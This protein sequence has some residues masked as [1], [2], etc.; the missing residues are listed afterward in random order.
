MQI[1]KI[2]ANLTGNFRVNQ[3]NKAQASKVS[4]SISANSVMSKSAADA[5]RAQVSFGSTHAI[6]N[7]KNIQ[8]SP[9]EY[10][11][12]TEE[13]KHGKEFDIKKGDKTIARGFIGKSMSDK[14]TVEFNSAKHA[15]EVKITFNEDG[16]TIQMF[17]GSILKAGEKDNALFIELPGKYETVDGQQK[18]SKPVSFKGTTVSLLCK[19]DST[20]KATEDSR[21]AAHIED[22]LFSEEVKADDPNFVVLAGGFGTRFANMTAADQNKPSFVM[23]NGLSILSS[24]YDLIKNSTAQDTLGNITYLE[25][26]SDENPAVTKGLVPSRDNLIP[27][28]A[29]GSDGGAVV[30][31]ILDGSIS[32]DKPLIILNADT[33]TN[34]DIS[35]AYHCLNKIENAGLVI[36]RY[37]V[38]ET[39]AKSFGLMSAGEKVQDCFVLDKFVEKP[40]DPKTM[41]KGAMVAGEKVN[42]EQ[43]YYGNPGIYIF[44]KEVVNM[45]HEIVEEAMANAEGCDFGNAKV[46][47]L[48]KTIVPTI[49]KL[50]NEGKIKNADGTELKAY[51][52]PM[53]TVEGKDAYWDD[54]GTAEAFVHT[55]QQIAYETKRNGLENNKF[56]GIRGLKDFRN[57]VDTKT[58]VCFAS[59]QVKADF[60]AAHSDIKIEGDAYIS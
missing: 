56:I 31:G 8:I 24:A 14:V 38:S 26:N 5:L 3:A 55:T 1:S 36:P 46:T 28:E 44:G 23:P 20:I 60:K 32:K 42:G 9:S 19:K 59:P 13:K 43:A 49:V 4:N 39:R 33:L 2:S 50:C 57:S 21:D 53:V 6:L 48:G 51:M 7:S 25:Q 16:R 29:F 58:G 10:D 27:M 54:I 30:R 22:G 11:V 52:A 18:T 47:G 34:V 15:P 41:A 40:E 35:Q 17:E 12:E 45:M 37:K